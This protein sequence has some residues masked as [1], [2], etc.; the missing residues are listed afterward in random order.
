VK[1]RVK[2]F[3]VIGGG[4]LGFRLP[5]VAMDEGGDDEN[6][7]GVGSWSPVR[8]AHGDDIIFYVHVYT[9]CAI[10]NVKASHD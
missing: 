4:R 9:K 2:R 10:G 3:G 5:V 1:K 8:G 6:S 7:S